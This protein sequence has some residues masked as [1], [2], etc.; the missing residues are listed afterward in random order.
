VMAEGAIVQEGT[1]ADVAARPRTQHVAALV[2][3][4]LVRGDAVDGVITVPGGTSLVAA[5]RLSGPAFAAFS[6]ASVS[7]FTERPSG[8]PRN[9]WAGTVLSLAPHGDA[10]RVL[11]DADATLLADITP[12]AMASLGLHAGTPLWASVKATEVSIYPA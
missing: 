1:P 4:N 5:E 6:P 3:L 7:L 11:V 2:G 8:S 12:A 10:V 9:V